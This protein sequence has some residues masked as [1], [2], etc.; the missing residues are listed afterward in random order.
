MAKSATC[1]RCGREIEMGE[2]YGRIDMRRM[3]SEHRSDKNSMR[4]FRRSQAVLTGTV[5]LACLDEV[6]IS[7]NAESGI[8]LREAV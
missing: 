4:R 7:V 2:D 3:A 1:C 6:A 5:C 8:P